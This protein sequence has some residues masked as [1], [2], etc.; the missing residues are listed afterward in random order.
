M[1]KSNS[2]QILNPIK[3]ISRRFISTRKDPSFVTPQEFVKEH[4]LAY[5]SRTQKPITKY[6][7]DRKRYAYDED[8]L[9]RIEKDEN[10][11][12]ITE[13]RV[14]P[15]TTFLGPEFEL[16]IPEL[17]CVAY[18]LSNTEIIINENKEDP[19]NNVIYETKKLRQLG[20]I[21]Y[22]YTLLTDTVFKSPEYL[23][24]LDETVKY[25]MEVLVKDN[26]LITEFMK[27][28]KLYDCS[29]VDSQFNVRRIHVHRN[30]GEERHQFIQYVKDQTVVGSFYTMLGFLLIKY[31]RESTKKFIQSNIIHA[32]HGILQIIYTRLS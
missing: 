2:K 29:F 13:N 30:I 12:G 28:S 9:T 5:S 7:Q 31:G 20:K 17:T 23:S 18:G 32:P 4:G 27:S 3:R 1:L 10:Y 8:T 6:S 25:D 21:L 11:R 14:K 24:R 15:Y 26:S 22:Q 19:L 16:N